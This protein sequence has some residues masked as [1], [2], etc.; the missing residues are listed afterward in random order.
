MS[1]S[2]DLEN[3][4]LAK[5]GVIL[6]MDNGL[7]CFLNPDSNNDIVSYPRKNTSK[8]Q[9]YSHNKRS[10]LI[11]FWLDDRSLKLYD[12]FIRKWKTEFFVYRNLV[13]QLNDRIL[14]DNDRSL[15]SKWSHSFEMKRSY[16]SV[17]RVF[18]VERSYYVWNMIVYF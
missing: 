17:E 8:L 10:V 1:E 13:I 16:T 2:I 9:S 6:D 4:H 14:S 5:I 11:S 7:I 12:I 3:I 18:W 15:L